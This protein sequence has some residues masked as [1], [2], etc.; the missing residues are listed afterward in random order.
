MKC[1]RTLK[2]ASP[3]CFEKKT[4]FGRIIPPFFFE[5][6]ESD[7][8]LND[9]HDSNSIFRVGGIDSEWVFRCKV[10]SCV[11]GW[12]GGWVGGWL[13]G[14]VVGRFVGWSVRS[15]CPQPDRPKSRFCFCFLLWWF[16]LCLPFFWAVS[17]RRR[18][19]GE[20]SRI[21]PDKAENTP[22]DDRKK[23]E[24]L[25]KKARTLRKTLRKEATQ[26][27]NHHRPEQKQHEML[28]PSPG[29]P[30]HIARSRTGT[31][32]SWTQ[33]FFRVSCTDEFFSSG[34]KVVPK[35]LP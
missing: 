32:T 2:P 28:G 16:P 17:K 7:R 31:R 10:F 26:R 20:H 15:W 4:F 25:Q 8:V 24:T 19:S 3:E 22:E 1:F 14:W 21:W 34:N 11:V 23:R 27:G 29:P 13:G 6:S 33:K 35:S 12:V 5:S 18:A 9:L 30:S